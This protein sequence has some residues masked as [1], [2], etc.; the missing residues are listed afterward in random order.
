MEKDN[1]GISLSKNKEKSWERKICKDCQKDNQRVYSKNNRKK[2]NEKMSKFRKNNPDKIAKSKQTYYKNNKEKIISKS[3]DYT[4]KNTDKVKTYQE[5]YR[6]ENAKQISEKNKQYRSSHKEALLI[7]QKEKYK[8]NIN[9]RLRQIISSAIRKALFKNKSSKSGNSFLKNIPYTIEQLKKHIESK[10]DLWM[11][12][13]NYGTYN[14]TWD[15]KNQLTWKW[16]IDH[17]I[18]HSKL[19]YS[20]MEDE[21]F[22][23]CWSLDNLRPYAAKQ[24]VLDGNRKN[25][26]IGDM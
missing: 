5:K 13:G 4:S 14:N 6:K 22:K 12:W 23:K 20:S 21:N 16:N 17:I 2:L 7:K 3:K 24:N 10:F 9:I 19:P 18:P 8:E 25:L 15:D 1:F 26:F 11:N